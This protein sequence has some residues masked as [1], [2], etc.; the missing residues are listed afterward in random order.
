M[1]KGEYITSL[2]R[3]KKTVFSF[4][5]LALLWGNSG[6]AMLKRV[7]YYV[8]NGQ[9]YSPRRGF[10]A[11]DENYIRFE[12]AC[13]I[14]T[15]SYISFESVLARE[16]MIFQHY[17]EI[18]VASYKTRSIV[19][20]NQT[21]SYRR[22]KGLVL[23]NPAG[24]ENTEE[25]SIASKERAF[26]DTV[27]VNKEYHFDNLSPL[28]WDKVFEILPAYSNIAMEKRVKA[29]YCNLKEQADAGDG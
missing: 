10:Y 24:V 21:Y 13:K 3:S 29:L 18:F 17:K 4:K 9:I 26:L 11:K 20:D 8:K 12:L 15:P 19:S 25:Y 1:K 7:G 27:Y 16:G 6:N 14:Y 28:D 22:I 23:T 2:L 5:D